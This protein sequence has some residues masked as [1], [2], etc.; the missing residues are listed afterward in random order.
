MLLVLLAFCCCCGRC[1]QVFTHSSCN[2]LLCPCSRPKDSSKDNM[3]I[4]DATIC[5]SEYDENWLDEQFMPCLSQFENNYKI[6]KLSLYNRSSDKISRENEKVL[7]S[8]KRIILIFSRKFLKEEWSNNSFRNV[9]RD[10]CIDKNN[11]YCVLIV[12]NVGALTQSDI[13]YHLRYLEM[14]DKHLNDLANYSRGSEEGDS[15]PVLKKKSIWSRIGDRCRYNFGLKK[16]ETLQISDRSFWRKF[17][18]VMPRI[19]YDNTKPAIIT[20]GKSSLPIKRQARQEDDEY[21][22]EYKNVKSLRHIIV[23][24]PDFMRTQLGFNKKSKKLQLEE[25]GKTDKHTHRIS[26][27]KN[28]FNQQ[29]Y[30]VG[31]KVNSF[32]ALP[33][34]P[35]STTNTTPENQFS[36]RN[37]HKRAVPSRSPSRTQNLSVIDTSQNNYKL[38]AQSPTES[39]ETRST[40]SRRRS[41]AS[42][43][44]ASVKLDRNTIIKETPE[45]RTRSSSRQ[46]SPDKYDRSELRSAERSHRRRSED[47]SRLSTTSSKFH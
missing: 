27:N 21:A 24:I 10:I 22:S 34:S 35:T 1:T 8:S 30:D 39:L 40:S 28:D 18:Y 19:R 17:L 26:L 31:K 6:H 43:V 45:R 15:F 12:V 20:K 41:D 11:K 25:L 44:F 3:K 46:K 36:S 16:I 37:Y 5:Y 23:P 7:R 29:D 4:Y 13:D 2:L 38:R 33:F 42:D 9:L 47:G 14:P 32:S